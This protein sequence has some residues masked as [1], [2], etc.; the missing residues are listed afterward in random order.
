[1]SQLTP[2]VRSL[3]RGAFLVLFAGFILGPLIVLALW[4]L[5]HQWFWPSLL[6]SAF[7]LRW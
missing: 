3:L 7:T 1:M 6:P 4:S 5:A 2:M